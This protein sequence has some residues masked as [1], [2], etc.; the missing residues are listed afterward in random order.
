MAENKTTAPPNTHHPGVIAGRQLVAVLFDLD[1]TLIETDDRAVQ[2]LA[3]RLAFLRPLLPQGDA[4]QAARRL[5]MWSHDW[6]HGWLVWLDRLAL[7][8]FS[9]R[10]AQRLGLLNDNLAGHAPAPVAG[11]TAL[12]RQ[13]AGRY[14]LGIVSTRRVKE[15]LVYLEQ[16]QLR[17]VIEV[18]V[19]SDTTPR[20]KP[21]PQPVLWAASRLAVPVDRTVLVGDTVAD[22]RAAHAAGALAVGVLCG[23]GEPKDLRQADLI[24]PSTAELA[25]WL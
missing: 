5:I 13:L 8:G 24:L 10:L 22:V 23:F 25:D 19:G 11:T 12:L 1:G 18:V 2:H 6:V 3:Q 20:I 14:R 9:Q 7:D 17:D 21:H 15:V 16:E 4:Q